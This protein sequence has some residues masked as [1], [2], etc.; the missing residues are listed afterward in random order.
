M[1]IALPESSADPKDVEWDHFMGA[2]KQS[3]SML[4]DLG[5]VKS[6]LRIDSQCW[7]INKDG[8]RFPLYRDFKNGLVYRW[9]DVILTCNE[10]ESE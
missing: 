10:A 8:K 9:E 4:I 1:R 3:I 7:L 6:V 5:Y 2:N